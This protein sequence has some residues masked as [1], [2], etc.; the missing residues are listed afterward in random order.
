MSADNTCTGSTAEDDTQR[1]QQIHHHGLGTFTKPVMMKAAL[2]VTLFASASG[3]LSSSA[4][5][6]QSAASGRPL[7]SS[8]NLPVV[9]SSGEL[10][11]LI[12]EGTTIVF[13]HQTRCRR[14]RL[15]HELVQRLSLDQREQYRYYVQVVCDSSAG[16]LALAQAEKVS[17]VRVFAAIHF[18]HSI[19]PCWLFALSLS[20]SLP[21]S[22]SLS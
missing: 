6:R 10:R 3:L 19:T 1:S 18:N 16:A 17:Q 13:F 12:A 4:P 20:L 21:P 22:L 2:V 8:S 11:E 7:A 15:V 5:G 9:G 14:C